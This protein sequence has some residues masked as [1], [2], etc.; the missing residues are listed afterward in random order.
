MKKLV[1]I[2]LFALVANLGI[3][4]SEIDS[5]F[6]FNFF[7]SEALYNRLQGNYSRAMD[8]YMTSLKFNKNS[9]VVYYEL[10]RIARVKNDIKS[11]NT[12]IDKALELEPRNIHYV[13]YA[14]SIKISDNQYPGAI[15]L[16]NVLLELDPENANSA[17][18]LERL[19]CSVG[20]KQNAL[21]VL[22]EKILPQDQGEID[23]INLERVDVYTKFGERKEAIK[24]LGKVLKQNPQSALY[25]YS[26]GSL[27]LQNGDTVNGKKY[28]DKAVTLSGGEQYLFDVAELNLYMHNIK[29]FYSIAAAAFENTDVDFYDKYSRLM[30]YTDE[31]L[32]NLR[33]KNNRIFI[34]RSFRKCF[35]L[36][37]E[38]EELY[39]F[40]AEYSLFTCGDTAT[41]MTNFK[42]LFE[43]SSSEVQE[44]YVFLDILP[45][46]SDDYV[47][48][49]TEAYRFYPNDYFIALNY[50]H[51]LLRDDNYAEAY[52]VCKPI[53]DRVI[54]EKPKQFYSNTL[55]T[56]ANIYHSLDSMKQCFEC[57]DLL[58]E[59]DEYNILALNNYAYFLAT[60]DGDL[61]KAEKM[62]R[63]AVSLEP[64]NP[65]YLDTYA[66]VLFCKRLYP[67]SKFIMEMAIANI[68]TLP[69]DEKETQLYLYYDHYGDILYHNGFYD[70][71]DKYWRK[72]IELNPDDEL[73]KKKV[74]INE[75]LK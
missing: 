36:Y 7:F 14:I 38:Q 63:T 74:E 31:S 29:D 46:T 50:T 1:L 17:I 45:Y 73:L 13:K 43:L 8:L 35:E 48:Y 56:M 72:A 64:N 24:Y 70:E 49:A 20:D 69:R 41:A 68:D 37:P 11:A 51:C 60:N 6:S 55:N 21:R 58:L 40:F 2:F 42:K 28:Y 47:H 15:D 54:V 12:F 25:T 67:D 23:F 3:A 10:S 9:S 27:L 5:P 4:Q 71:A 19:Y 34:D 75:Y 33:N 18:L 30:K 32:L 22:D 39:G 66:W 61:D 26:Y 57:Y 65:V 52:K 16:L 53:C 59:K 44:W 62:S